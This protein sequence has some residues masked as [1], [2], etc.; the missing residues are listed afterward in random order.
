MDLA[1]QLAQRSQEICQDND[2]TEDQHNCES[3][4]YINADMRILDICIPDYFQGC[5]APHACIPLPWHGTQD[6]LEAEVQSQCA[7]WEEG[8]P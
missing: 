2:C 7:E 5:S 6:E 3:F 8:M 1:Y 4:A